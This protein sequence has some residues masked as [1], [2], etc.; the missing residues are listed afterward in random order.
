MI[1]HVQDSSPCSLQILG[2]VNHGWQQVERE[3]F[4]A[5]LR[6]RGLQLTEGLYSI[7]DK[8]NEI[9]SRTAAFS[10]F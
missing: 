9:L 5:A 4:D 6:D 1:V 2:G 8:N 10:F 3:V 7:T